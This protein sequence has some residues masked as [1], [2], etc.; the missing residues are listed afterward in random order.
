MFE[1]AELGRALPRE[2][3]DRQ[4]PEL[5]TELLRAQHDLA[6]ADFPVIVLFHGVEGAGKGETLNLL[7]EWLDTRYLS[8]HAFGDPTDEAAQ[9]PPHWRYWMATPPRGRIGFFVGSWYSDP[10]QRRVEAESTDS[11]LDTAL[12]RIRALEQALVAD[13]ALIIKLWFHVAQSTQRHRFEQL[14]SDEATRWR[15]TKSDWKHHRRYDEFV[16]VAGRVI[17]ETSTGDAPWTLI[18][19]TDHRYR[20][21]TVA[22][23]L[24]SRIRARLA[25]PSTSRPVVAAPTEVANPVTIFDQLDL[26]QRVE[27]ETYST[28]LEHLQGR[29]NRLARR[30]S[31]RRRGLI[32]LFEGPDASGKGGAIRRLTHAFDARH[33]RV[34]PIAAPTAEEREHHYLWRFWRHLPRLGRITIYD[35]S[36][37]GRV[38]V[39]RVEGFAAESEWQRAY[40]EINDFERQLVEHRNVLVK[41]WL[42]ISGDEQ[43]RRFRDREAKPWKQYKITEEDYRNRAKTHLY[44]LAANDMITQN[45]TDYA[46]F[47]LIPAEDKRFARLAVLRTVAER[48]EATLGP[49]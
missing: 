21:A 27:K 14:E 11:E 37:Y 48:I 34:I 44:E 5:R 8:T 28:E 2:E 17:R 15:V 3:F 4:I 40:Q 10:L 46:P 31:K 13:G 1:T 19:G 47:T 45:S 42:H 25:A 32:V 36:W 39:E 16:R 7:H 6:R 33:Y 29:L 23:H 20:N 9:R 49:E 12:L 18:E 30:L 26:T 43:L 24:A 38:L 22:R 35:R 41:L